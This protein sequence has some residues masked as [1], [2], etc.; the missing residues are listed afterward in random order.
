MVRWM[1][2]VSSMLLP[3]TPSIRRLWLAVCSNR[4]W[5]GFVVLMEARMEN[6]TRIKLNNLS[7]TIFVDSLSLV[8]RHFNLTNK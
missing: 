5:R 3:S 1:S 6:S 7:E 8:F 2:G 4:I